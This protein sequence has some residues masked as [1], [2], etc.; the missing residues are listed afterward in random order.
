MNKIRE[1]LIALCSFSLSVVLYESKNMIATVLFYPEK[2]LMKGCRGSLSGK[3]LSP[4]CQFISVLD[5]CFCGLLVY[6]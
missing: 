1:T 5:P 3:A 2:I 4:A 6:L